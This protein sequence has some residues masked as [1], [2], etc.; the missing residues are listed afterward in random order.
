MQPCVIFANVQ[1]AQILFNE[2][3]KY[4]IFNQPRAL[5]QQEKHNGSSPKNALKP[6]PRAP[7]I[8]T[9][10]K[11]KN[12]DKMTITLTSPIRQIN[13]HCVLPLRSLRPQLETTLGDLC[14]PG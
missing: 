12:Y 14:P 5:E 8:L 7:S 4:S 2:L 10:T 11:K 9:L 3:N 13:W 1:V 6:L